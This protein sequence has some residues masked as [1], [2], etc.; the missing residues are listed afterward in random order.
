MSGP[1]G[2]LIAASFGVKNPARQR[3]GNLAMRKVL[4][5]TDPRR[6]SIFPKRGQ[7]G[8]GIFGTFSRANML[9]DI[10]QKEDKRKKQHGAGLL[11]FITRPLARLFGKKVTKQAAKAVAKR[12]AKK[13]AKKAAAG[14]VTAGA[15]WATQK[16]LD[17]I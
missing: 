13:A 8:A 4:M 14:A 1:F 2:D 7:R 9:L 5:A 6:L 16:A 17:Q 10:L 12:V 15:S 11:S 3:G